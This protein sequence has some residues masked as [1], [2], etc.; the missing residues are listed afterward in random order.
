MAPNRA[1]HHIYLAKI[2][3]IICVISGEILVDFV[4]FFPF[5]ESQNPAGI[6]GKILPGSYQNLLRS[7]NCFVKIWWVGSHLE[8]R[9]D[10]ER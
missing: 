2:L 10:K 7:Y 6:L 4:E 5:E 9:R 8:I 3:W 1:T